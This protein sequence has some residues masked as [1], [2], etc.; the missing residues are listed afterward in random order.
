MARGPL[1]APGFIDVHLHGFGGFDATGD[2]AALAGMA[3]GLLGHGVTSFVPTAP[4]LALAELPRFVGRVRDFAAAAPADGA[5]P[6]GANLEAVPRAA[7][8]GAHEPS[9]LREPADLGDPLLDA[10][11][12]G[13]RIMTVAPELP[14]RSRSSPR[15][16]SRGV[17]ASLGH[18]ESSLDE[19]PGELFM[20]APTALHLFNAMSVLGHRRRPTLA[21]AALARDD[22]YVGSSRTGF[23]VHPR[24]VAAHRPREACKSP[25]AG[26]RRAAA[27]GLGD[28]DA[29]SAGWRS[30]CAVGARRSRA[31]TRSLAR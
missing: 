2:S 20:N 3:R 5:E 22:A 7:R 12:T 18:S 28:G 1:I 4:S 9:L 17:A 19:A 21:A 10:I 25:P 23:H 27:C 13:L 16:A 26:Q 29:A 6:L 14:G 30:A 8:K 24:A 31:R 15:L 11:G